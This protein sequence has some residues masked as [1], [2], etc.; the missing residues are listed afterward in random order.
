MNSFGNESQANLATCHQDLQIVM[1]ES[2]RLSPIDFGIVY[3]HRPPERQLE[4]FRQGRTLVDGIWVVVDKK[5]VVTN[6]DG[7][8]D[9][10]KHNYLPS[11]ACDVRIFIEG[12]SDLAY[13]PEHLSH[14]AGI[15]LTVA[16]YLYNRKLISHRIC[17]GGN[18]DGDGII[19]QDQT[20]WDRPHY[21]IIE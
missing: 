19:L 9:L 12:R 18:W 15:V 13:D 5:K 7:Y 10:S 1:K 8:K 6:C 4:M 20:L 21:E 3:G 14:V 2:I 17:W 16:A 11:K